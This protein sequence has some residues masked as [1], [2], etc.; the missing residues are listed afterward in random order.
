VDP[1]PTNSNTDD[2]LYVGGDLGVY[3]STDLGATWTKF[4]N[5]LAVSQVRDLEYSPQTHILAA[6]THG[7][8][9][10]E[11]LA[12]PPAGQIFGAVYNDANSNAV[13]DN[14]EAGLGGW[15]VFRDDNNNGVLDTYGTSNI[16]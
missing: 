11:I 16:S 13:L 6:A 14:G 9:I 10:W 1:G 3:R 15:T 4:G 7:R 8:G 2:I 12:A 5:G